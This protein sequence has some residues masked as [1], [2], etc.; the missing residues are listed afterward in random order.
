MSQVFVLLVIIELLNIALLRL[1]CVRAF[2]SSLLETDL[3]VV[4]DERVVDLLLL[5]ECEVLL[6]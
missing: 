6:C 4:A 3:H 5:Q 1:G 2:H